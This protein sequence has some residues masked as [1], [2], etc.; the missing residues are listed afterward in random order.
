MREPIEL[1]DLD[2]IMREYLVHSGYQESFVALDQEN[3]SNG[4][5]KPA[6]D[7]FDEDEVADLQF[8]K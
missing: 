8:F 2:Y 6:E 1:G 7:G 4:I 5:V 3:V